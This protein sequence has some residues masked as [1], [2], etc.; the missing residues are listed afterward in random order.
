MSVL[1]DPMWDEVNPLSVYC[2][3]LVTSDLVPVLYFSL[4]ENDLTDR[5]RSQG[6]TFSDNVYQ[7]S[8]L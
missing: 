4:K 6:Q 2:Y 8:S 5:N 3:L 7:L 1:I